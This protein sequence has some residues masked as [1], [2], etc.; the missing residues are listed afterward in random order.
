MDDNL[1]SIIVPCYNVAGTLVRYLDSILAQTYQNLEVI[2]VDDGSTDHTAEILNAYEEKFREH[3]MQ[4]KYIYEKNAGLGA[5]INTGL[6]HVA[7]DFLC[8]SDPDDFYMRDSMKKRLDLLLKYP[9]YGVVSS[10][11]YVYKEDDLI[12]PLKR[13][14]TRFEHRFE[15]NQFWLLLTEQSHFCAGCHM[16]RMSAFDQV[17]PQREIYP[18][19]RGQNWQLLLPVYY[20]FKRYYIDEPLYCCVAY[21]NSMSSG[22]N[23]E[24]KELFRWQEHEDIIRNTLLRIH[25]SSEDT[26][27]SEHIVAVRYALKRFYTAIDYRD[28]KLLEEQY[29]ILEDLNEDTNDVKHLFLRNHNLF[30]KVYYKI[31]DISHDK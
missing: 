17:N 14:A 8:W 24:E 16:I 20:S 3:H 29:H 30:W 22:D 21:N 13:E 10:D 5:A 18:A 26:T 11:A 7:G 1:I 2:A 23:T 6:K 27:K 19:R 31:K 28:R 9:D 25:M 15:E 12:H 4:L